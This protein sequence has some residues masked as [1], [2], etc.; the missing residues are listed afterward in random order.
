MLG[1]ESLPFVAVA[2]PGSPADR[3]GIRQGDTLLSVNGKPLPAAADEYYTYIVVNNVE[4]PRYRR[5]VDRMLA[6]A[7]E[8]GLPVEIAIRRDGEEISTS[9]R[10]E[11]VCDYNVLLV[12]DS[13]LGIAGEGKTVL[14]SSGLYDFAASDAEIQV[15]IAHQ[16]AHIAERHGAE[17]TRNS[18][19]GGLLGGAA[20]LYVVAPV[21]VAGVLGAG[22]SG[23]EIE[24]DV[25]GLGSVVEGSGRFFSRLGGGMFALSR[26]READYVALYMLERSG[27]SAAEAVA[28]W[29]RVPAD[30]PLARTHAG[31]EERLENM[32]A[33][34]REIGRKRTVGAPLVPNENRSPVAGKD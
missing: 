28:F 20:A 17:K 8:S 1:V 30:A 18:L 5:R 25:E 6:Q 29:R 11:D 7:V 19:I 12:E 15:A 21:A 16:L 31:M 2:T 9:V 10:P 34:V 26:E 32:D 24:G 33:T 14:M 4:L 23:G 22:M 27:V 13:D 3:A